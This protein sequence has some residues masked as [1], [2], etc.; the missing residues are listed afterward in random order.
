MLLLFFLAAL[1][2]LT[3]LGYFAGQRRA[4]AAVKGQHVGRSLST[5]SFGLAALPSFYGQRLAYLVFL[6]PFVLLLIWWLVEPRLADA[7][8]AWNLPA[9]AAEASKGE[10][11]G[12]LA[13]IRD[14]AE[15]RP[16]LPEGDYQAAVDALQSLNWVS[17]TGVY[18][19]LG[20]LT[21]ALLGL[22][23]ATSKPGFRARK[24]VESWNR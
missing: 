13:K 1:L 10:L 9:E 17:S 7:L 4:L 18:L 16:G 3:V 2:A 6:P 21:L 19:L 8:I 11:V 12:I 5:N 20:L 15:G 22:G 23:L 14:A 24:A